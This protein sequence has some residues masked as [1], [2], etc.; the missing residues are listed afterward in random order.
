MYTLQTVQCVCEIVHR[1]NEHNPS[2][3]YLFRLYQNTIEQGCLVV[4]FYIIICIII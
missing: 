4:L 1:P 2:P 3:N